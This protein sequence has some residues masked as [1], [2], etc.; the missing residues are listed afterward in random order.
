MV[1][2]QNIHAGRREIRASIGAIGPFL[3]QAH[4][5][6]RSGFQPGIERR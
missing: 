1:E 4:L 5:V 6:A 3:I 2:S